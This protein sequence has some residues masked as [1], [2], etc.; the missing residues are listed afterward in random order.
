MTT[1]GDFAPVAATLR[2]EIEQYFAGRGRDEGE[3][4]L[5]MTI[6]TNSDLVERR[7]LPLVGMLAGAGLPSL[8]GVRLLDVGCGFGALA[9]YFAVHGAQVHAIDVNPSRFSVGRAVAARHDLAVTFHEG[10]MQDLP[11][12]DEPFG[13]GIMNNTF[14]YLLGA[15]DRRAA[16]TGVSRSLRPSGLLLVRELNGWHP[17]DQFTGL[18]LLAML[19]PQRA[20]R[21]VRALG[22]HRPDVR[23]ASPRALAG[24]LRSAGFADV[25]H[26]RDQP[27]RVARLTRNLARYQH[28]IARK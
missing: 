5:R 28:V 25:R 11:T 1:A 18:P 24:E 19:A 14:C 16:L 7:A 12:F 23:I 4:R 10:H 27:G 2:S 17:L 8:A 9:A 6:A 3:Q 21:V 13:V 26:L 15:G 22:M 20:S